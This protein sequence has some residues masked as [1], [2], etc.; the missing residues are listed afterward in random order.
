MP[1]NSD[2]MLAALTEGVESSAPTAPAAEDTSTEGGQSNA[3]ES[4]AS[5]ETADD[6]S[7]EGDAP[8]ADGAAG[9]DASA[10][11]GEQEPVADSAGAGEQPADGKRA[12]GADGKF[13]AKDKKPEGDPKAGAEPKKPDLINDPIPDTVKKETRERIQGLISMNKS[14]TSERDTAVAQRD[15]LLTHI[16]ESKA[17]PE[18]YGD[19]LQTLSWLNSGDPAQMKQAYDYL[20]GEVRGLGRLLGIPVPG[21]DLLSAHEDLARKVAE[22][23]MSQEDAEQVAAARDRVSVE[24]QRSKQTQ[25]QQLQQQ[26]QEQAIEKAK[27]DLRALGARLQAADPHFQ[28][29]AAAMKPLI[30]NMLRVTH[31]SQ[32]VKLYEQQYAVFP[33]TPP[34]KAAAPG[35]RVPT[36]Q[37]M[38][39]NKQPSGGQIKAP[40]SMLEAI[41]AGVAQ[42][43]K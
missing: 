18:Q 15:E 23:Q 35:A 21:T 41:S 13:L 5:G 22:G 39:A 12:R 6:G 4:T 43:G 10:K 16:E 42:A 34:V 17:T 14:V 2:E 7:A 36:N 26:R 32:W 19:A 8:A 3:T 29:K 20:M 37:P 40:S 30:Q 38:R 9:G 28:A 25:E 1:I 24:T 11:D 27:V 33:F 31:P